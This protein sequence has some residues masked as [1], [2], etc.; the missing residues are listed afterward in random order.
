MIVVTLESAKAEILALRTKCGLDLNLEVVTLPGGSSSGIGPC[1]NEPDSEVE[2]T[3]DAIRLI[4]GHLK[5]ARI[6]IVSGDL[7]TDV[8]INRIAD[9]HRAHRSAVTALF[10][11][12]WVEP[13]DVQIPGPKTKPKKGHWQPMK[14]SRF[15]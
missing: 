9:L 5:A 4:H 12:L 10:S 7:I 13:K 11:P 3:A 14:Y 8:Q 6:M 2:G 15:F 1:N